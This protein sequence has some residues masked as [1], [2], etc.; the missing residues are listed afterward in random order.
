MAGKSQLPSE[1]RQAFYSG[2]V[3]GVGFR[4]SV[5]QLAGGFDVAGFVRNL[6]DGRVELVA[7]GASA[8]LDEFM[9]AVGER[10]ADYIRDVAVDIRPGT[11][12]FTSFEIRH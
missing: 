12:E 6:S 3:Q 10:M 2:Q 11:G 5:R 1:R 9:A 7:E 4:Y 8:E